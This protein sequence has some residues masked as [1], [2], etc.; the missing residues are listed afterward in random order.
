MN[1]I[2]LGAPGA[3]KGTQADVI[4]QKLQIPAI[5]TGKLLR[6]AVKNQTEL[7][8]AAQSY[9][10]GGQ[11]VPDE[12]VVS[13]LGQRL[14]EDDCK[15]GFILD[16]F[17]RTLAQAEALDRLGVTIDR[18]IDL[19]VSDEA[20]TRR[21]SGRRVCPNCGASYHVEYNPPK[22]EGI[23]DKCGSAVQ[24]RKDDEPATVQ[25]RLR[26]YH[27]QTEPLIAYYRGQNKLYTVIGQDQIAETSAL[28][29]QALGE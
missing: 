26:V 21:M 28:T 22:T 7:G 14:V 19:E 18:V 17:P 1:L 9:M 4:C 25:E 23:C 13:M 12:L 2:L 16:G 5:S 10:D 11:L 20:I 3:G 29:L 27:T 24:L 8:I 6:E 15:S